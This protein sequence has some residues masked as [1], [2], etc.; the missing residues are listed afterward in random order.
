MDGFFWGVGEP[1]L[2]ILFSSRAVTSKHAPCR[3]KAHTK[4]PKSAKAP[5]AAV[6][7]AGGHVQKPPGALCIPA[8]RAARGSD[9]DFLGIF[10]IAFVEFPGLDVALAPRLT[11]RS[12]PRRVLAG[13]D[14]HHHS[15]LLLC[16][17]SP[18][19]QAP[20]AGPAAAT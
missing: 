8:F 11:S 17:P 3:A 6:P 18:T 1:E 15:Q 2:R 9:L 4:L 16:L 14:H 13:V 7:Y 5:R 20:S 10:P 19:H 12:P